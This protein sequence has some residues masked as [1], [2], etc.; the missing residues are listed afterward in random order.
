MIKMIIKGRS[1]TMRHVS[2]T[3]RFARD[4][5]FDRINLDPKIQIKY[6]D[7]KNQ[8]ADIM[9]KGSFTHDEWCNLLRLFHIMIFTLFSCIHLSHFLSDP[10]LILPGTRKPC[11]REAKKELPATVHRCEGK[12]HEPGVTQFERSVECEEQLCARLE[13]SRK[14]WKATTDMSSVYTRCREL[15]RSTS[16][17]LVEPSQAWKQENAQNTEAWEQDTQGTS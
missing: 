17:D 4:W 10:L 3:H 11:Q 2:R 15:W 14:P 1:P 12:T 6:V 16:K 13:Q 8:L 5:L 9:S 7:T